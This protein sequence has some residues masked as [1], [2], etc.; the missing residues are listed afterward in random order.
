[1]ECCPTERTTEYDRV[2]VSDISDGKKCHLRIETLE[3]EAGLMS[4]CAFVHSN[5][6]S[7]PHVAARPEC[8]RSSPERS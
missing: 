3:P 5:A 8:S 6:D 1:M 2:V 7:C 4:I